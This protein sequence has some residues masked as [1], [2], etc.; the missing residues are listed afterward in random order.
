MLLVIAISAATGL[1]TGLGTLPFWFVK[2]LPRRAFDGILGFGAG[3]MLSAATIGLLMEALEEVR[4]GGVLDP[5]KLAVVLAGFA[6]GFVILFTVDKFIPH[7]HAGGHH[8][9]LK[10][11]A[12]FHD[13]EHDKAE[14]EASSH[15]R[16]GVLISGALV[17]H[18]LPEGFAIGASFAGGDTMPLGWLVAS[19]VALQNICE[20]VV[21]SAPLRAGGVPAWRAMLVTGATG[22]TVPIAAIIGYLFSQHVGGALPFGLALAAGSLI[23][24]TSN[25]NH[26]GDPRPR[27]RVHGDHRHR[28]GLRVHHPDAGGPGHR[29]NGGRGLRRRRQGPSAAPTHMIVAGDRVTVVTRSRQPRSFSRDLSAGRP[30]ASRISLFAGR[31]RKRPPRRAASRLRRTGRPSCPRAPGGWGRAPAAAPA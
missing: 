15:V 16:Q 29:L 30:K 14:R 17:F 10:E 19:S 12:H 4:P 13:E 5:V 24:V 6:F 2:S 27:E 7:E 21:M 18:R 8:E 20:G 26:P 23:G 28:D 3:L 1:C 22:L 9:H 25:E 11:G 31:A